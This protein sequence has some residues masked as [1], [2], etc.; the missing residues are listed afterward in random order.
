MIAFILNDPKLLHADI[1]V[2]MC[3]LTSPLLLR[4]V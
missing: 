1:L 2:G 3:I 4:V